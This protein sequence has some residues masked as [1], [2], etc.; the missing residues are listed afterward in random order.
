[1]MGTPA[2]AYSKLRET[3]VADPAAEVLMALA[4]AVDQ[5]DGHTAHHC[6]RLGSLCVVLGAALGLDDGSLQTLY[7]GGCLHDVGKVG[8][9]DAILF[10]PGRLT[11]DEWVVMRCHATQGE[12]ICRH[13]SSLAPVLPLI[14][15]HHERWDG[16]G[17][18]DGLRGEQIPYLARVLQVVDIYDA[19]TNPRPYKPAFSAE[20]ALRTLREETQ[21]G[22]RDPDIVRAFLEVHAGID[23]NLAA[24]GETLAQ[25][26]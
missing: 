24:I 11:E 16:S 7:R 20:E 1:M 14:R 12:A 17:Y 10:K 15:H 5:R 21:R 2:F 13:L 19:L 4:E 22:W 9:P 25:L 23:R 26:R 18:P 3:V 6:Q 8:V